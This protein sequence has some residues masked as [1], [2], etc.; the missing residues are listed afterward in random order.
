MSKQVC[1]QSC[2]K[3][4]TGRAK[5]DVA[6][7]LVSMFLHEVSRRIA[8]ELRLRVSD[9]PYAQQVEKSFGPNCAFCEIQ[10]ER[11]RLAVEHLEG[12]N[13]VRL[14]L[15]IPGNVVLACKECNREKR[16]DDQL[17][18]LVLAQTGWGSFLAH[19]RKRCPS[20]CKTCGYWESKW[21]DESIR[22]NKLSAAV[23]RIQSFQDQFTSFANRASELKAIIR[24]DVEA[25]Y[26]EGQDFA[27][28]R[29]SQLTSELL[30]T[31]FGKS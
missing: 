8:A 7:K 29:I 15:H 21:P 14:G 11:D 2:L 25:L 6:N 5:S 16:R 20:S 9:E 26:R 17:E 24:R 27:T 28:S 12:M 3:K 1:V 23:I 22:S 10:L 30:S 31:N 4:A 19:N 18:S 13:R